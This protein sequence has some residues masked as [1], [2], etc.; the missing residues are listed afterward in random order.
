MWAAPMVLDSRKHK[1]GWDS[2]RSGRNDDSDPSTLYSIL[3]DLIKM[4]VVQRDGRE[5][6]QLVILIFF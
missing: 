3:K 4:G 1:D 5:M 6:L 2:L